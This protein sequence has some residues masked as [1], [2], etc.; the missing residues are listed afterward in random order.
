MKEE[1]KRVENWET[2]EIECLGCGKKIFLWFNGGE[3]DR[4]DCCG[5]R[6]ETEHK[7]IDLVISKLP[8]PTD[9]PL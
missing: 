7:Q 5:Y 1:I 2:G 3:L 8:T 4:R 9:K 6:Y